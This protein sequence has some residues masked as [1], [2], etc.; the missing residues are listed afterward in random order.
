MHKGI[1]LCAESLLAL[2]VC[3]FGAT[4]LTR[5]LLPHLLSVLLARMT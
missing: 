3:R 2:L 5:I 4:A 1:Q